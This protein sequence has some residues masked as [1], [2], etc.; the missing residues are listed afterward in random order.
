MPG[1]KAANYPGKTRD[2]NMLS[3][4]VLLG[5][6]LVIIPTTYIADRQLFT[7]TNTAAV[8]QLES[9]LNCTSPYNASFHGITNLQQS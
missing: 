1:Q 7:A 2:V 6:G 9:G 8:R 5:Y 3:N 4:S